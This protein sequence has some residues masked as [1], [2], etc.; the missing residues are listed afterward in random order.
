MVLSRHRVI[1]DSND[2]DDGVTE[3]EAIAGSCGVACYS[4]AYQY[5]D[6]DVVQLLHLLCF[7]DL[8]SPHPTK[9]AYGTTSL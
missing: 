4:R 5:G 7:L 9:T 1:I 3:H 6:L 2:R 8:S